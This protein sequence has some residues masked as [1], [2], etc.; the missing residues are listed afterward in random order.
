MELTWF[1]TAGF[2]IATGKHTILI[3]PY[4]SRNEKLVLALQPANTLS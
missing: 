1:G 4:L 2:S 3:D